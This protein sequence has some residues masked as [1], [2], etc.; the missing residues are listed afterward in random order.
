MVTVCLEHLHWRQDWRHDIKA[1]E[2]VLGVYV[3]VRWARSCKT[4]TEGGREGFISGACSLWMAAR[5]N[6]VEPWLIVIW[7][8]DLVPERYM[9][10]CKRITGPTLANIGWREVYV[11]VNN[12]ESQLVQSWFQSAIHTPRTDFTPG[13]GR[14]RK[15]SSYFTLV[16]PVRK[17]WC[18]LTLISSSRVCCTNKSLNKGANLIAFSC[19]DSFKQSFLGVTECRYQ[20][21]MAFQQMNCDFRSIDN[22]NGL[23]ILLISIFYLLPLCWL[24]FM[25]PLCLECMD[26]V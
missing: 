11:R 17:A 9:L 4:G 19:N 26:C 20:F 14:V 13:Q 7:A 23:I 1:T 8:P 15:W 12:D 25:T 24:R 16:F 3:N 22:R 6:Y 2:G 5:W 10:N 21:G 18:Q